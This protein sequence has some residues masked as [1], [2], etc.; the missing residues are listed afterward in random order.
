MRCEVTKLFCEKKLNEVKISR[1]NPDLER[2]LYDARKLPMRKPHQFGKV[3]RHYSFKKWET[4][5]SSYSSILI[6]RHI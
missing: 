5:I 6:I 2:V 3:L 1:P 4:R